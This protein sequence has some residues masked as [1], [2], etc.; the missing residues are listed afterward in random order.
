[1]FDCP[2]CGDSPLTRGKCQECDGTG[3]GDSLNSVIDVL[4]GTD[5]GK[6]EHCGGT[7]KC[8]TCGGSGQSW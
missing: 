4:A 3:I 6:C 7:G 1:M 2:E 8:P 5:E